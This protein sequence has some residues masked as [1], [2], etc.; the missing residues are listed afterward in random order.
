MTDER[1]QEIKGKISDAITALLDAQ[2]AMIADVQEPM[3][4]HN[5]E[6]LLGTE[7]CAAFLAA[8]RAESVTIDASRLFGA[9]K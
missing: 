3:Y 6:R 5:R 4:N 8:E 1:K 9:I 7:L 2:L